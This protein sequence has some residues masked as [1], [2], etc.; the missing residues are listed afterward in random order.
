MENN[1]VEFVEGPLSGQVL[2]VERREVPVYTIDEG[3]DTTQL[4]KRLC[5]LLICFII[6]LVFVLILKSF[7]C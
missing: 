4:W 1:R 3:S 6:F 2:P 5:V 7:H